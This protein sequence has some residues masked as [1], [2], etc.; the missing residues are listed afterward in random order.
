MDGFS[1]RGKGI[2]AVYGRRRV[3]KTYLIREHFKKQFLT[4]YQWSKN[5]AQ[6]LADQAQQ[7]PKEHGSSFALGFIFASILWCYRSRRRNRD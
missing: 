4:T 1:G 3:G 7:N 2:L 6:K 5:H